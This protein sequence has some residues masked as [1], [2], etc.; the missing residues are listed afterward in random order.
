MRILFLAVMQHVLQ[1]CEG[2]EK[3]VVFGPMQ[4]S[5]HWFY[6]AGLKAVLAWHKGVLEGR[7]S[8]GAGACV[9]PGFSAWRAL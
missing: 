3:F 7:G 8:W 5:L 6:P 1:A 9:A 2:R 4:C